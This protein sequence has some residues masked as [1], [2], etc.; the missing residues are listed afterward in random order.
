MIEASESFQFAGDVDEPRTTVEEERRYRK[1]RLAAAYRIFAMKNYDFSLAGHITVRDPEFDDQFW[2]APLGP[3]F[4]HIRASDLCRVDENGKI[5][6]GS[7]PINQAGFAIHSEIHKARPDAMAAAHGHSMYG[8]AWSTLGRLLDPISQDACFFYENHALF[9]TF[10]GIV[11]ETSEGAEIAKVLGNGRAVILQ[12]HGILSVGRSVD[13]AVATYMFLETACEA[14]L[15][16]E[17]AGKPILIPHDVASHTSKQGNESD[18]GAYAF[19]PLY[20]RVLREQPDF[21]D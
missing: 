4:G 7:G 16:A 21:Q 1:L 10:S 8:R 3:W 20:Q 13:S 2:V 18:P 14:Q 9:S 12:N 6:E 11:L 5:L 15:R 17:A 19:P